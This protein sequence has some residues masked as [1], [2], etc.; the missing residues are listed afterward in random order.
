MSEHTIEL[1]ATLVLTY[2][3]EGTRAGDDL[4]IHD[5]DI[6]IQIGKSFS[7]NVELSDLPRF[8]ARYV[9]ASI[10]VLHLESLRG[11]HRRERTPA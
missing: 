5:P 8:T 6:E 4:C 9:T 11:R 2:E 1:A 10:Q 7:E 3:T